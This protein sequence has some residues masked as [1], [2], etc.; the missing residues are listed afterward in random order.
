MRKSSLDLDQESTIISILAPR[1]FP[2]TGSSSKYFPILK[3]LFGC[4]AL[5]LVVVYLQGNTAWQ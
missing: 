5:L 2:V 1:D 3:L 4:V